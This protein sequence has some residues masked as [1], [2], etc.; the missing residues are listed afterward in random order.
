MSE[1]ESGRLHAHDVAIRNYIEKPLSLTELET[2]YWQC[3][4][5]INDLIRRTDED[6]S[7]ANYNKTLIAIAQNPHLLQRPIL[8]STTACEAEIGRPTIE[9]AKSF[10]EK[11]ILQKQ[12]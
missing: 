6:A 3:D 4:K 12:N 1:V 5:D 10:C 8:I 7:H 11:M 2:L 9:N